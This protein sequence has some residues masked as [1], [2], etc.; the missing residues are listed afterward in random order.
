M[1]WP[2][3]SYCR[4]FESNST[5]YQ[6]PFGAVCIKIQKVDGWAK[7]VDLW[8]RIPSVILG[9]RIDPRT[10]FDKCIDCSFGSFLAEQGFG[11]AHAKT[12]GWIWYDFSAS[13]RRMT[14]TIGAGAS[15]YM[16]LAVGGKYLDAWCPLYENWLKQQT[17]DCIYCIVVDWFWKYLNGVWVGFGIVVI[18]LIV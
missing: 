12:R 6:S 17:C 10:G 15:V 3:A 9:R 16:W 7:K 2:L 4:T 13:E 14:S 11:F 1:S 8:I 5:A 18:G